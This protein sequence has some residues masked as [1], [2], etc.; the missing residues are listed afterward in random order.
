MSGE[1]SAFGALVD[2]LRRTLDVHLA[3]KANPPRAK[4]SRKP[5]FQ[6]SV[7]RLPEI[8]R[9]QLPDWAELALIAGRENGRDVR[10]IGDADRRSA[11]M[12]WPSFED[13][14]LEL[15]E[16][17][18][19]HP[20]TA[21]IALRIAGDLA[22]KQIPAWEYVTVDLNLPITSVQLFDGW[23]LASINRTEDPSLPISY[24]GFLGDFWT[25]DLLHDRGFGALRR[26]RSARRL[27][28]ATA[29]ENDLIWPLL[30]LNLLDIPPVRAF[31]AYLVE[32]GR[33]I[34]CPAGG[35]R[36]GYLPS[37]VKL[38]HPQPLT[39]LPRKP[40]NLDRAIANRLGRYAA[41]M[42]SCLAALSVGDRRVLAR[43][44]EHHLYLAYH[45]GPTQPKLDGSYVSFRR[46]VTLEALLA[47]A[48][49]DHEGIGRKISQ[50]AAV[51]ANQDDNSRLA[52]RDIIK[53][54]YS[55]RSAFAHGSGRTRQVDHALLTSTVKIIIRRWLA[56]AAYHG[57]KRVAALLDDALL[58]TTV[59]DGLM[60]EIAEH[61]SRA[62]I[63]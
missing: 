34:L 57:A 55:A 33:R 23:Q 60:H 31:T 15:L 62:G 53:S 54:A 38:W 6:L 11:A 26:P 10:W 47:S 51:L 17:A 49:S 56:L 25:P 42:G 9:E 41:E 21:D 32:P 24:G 63:Q 14:A 1:L 27:D 44:T 4:R 16:H 39:I 2:G 13:D 58:S 3:E 29:G 8:L 48:D 61:E 30:T 37:E 45:E 28:E 12:I 59:R 18:G 43:A 20:N 5:R 46:T 50:R 7:S 40:H 22:G 19:E 35:L 36:E 52:V